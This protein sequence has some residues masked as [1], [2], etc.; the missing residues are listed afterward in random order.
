VAIEKPQTQI[1]S[2]K[3]DNIGKIGNFAK[4]PHDHTNPAKQHFNPVKDVKG[5]LQE[6]DRMKML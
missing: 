4:D 6:K 1:K 3:Y 2:A 5:C